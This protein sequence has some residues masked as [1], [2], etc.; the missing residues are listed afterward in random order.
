M[1]I[2]VIGTGYVGL[3]TGTCFAETGNEVICVDVDAAKVERL[4]QGHIPIF[5]PGLEAMV[6][7]NHAKGRLQF[8]T[9]L[10]LGINNSDISFIAVGTPPDED[11][12]ADLRHVLDVAKHIAHVATKKVIIGTKSTVPVGTGDKIEAIFKENLK[13]PFVVFSNPEFLKE[14]DAVGDFMKPDRIIVGLEHNGILTLLDELYAPFT[15]QKERL[16]IMNRRSAE[17]TKYAANAMLATRISFM[18]EMA[19]LC[20]KLGADINEVRK[21][22]G[23]DP[24]IG[25]AFLFAG[26]GYGGSCFPKDVKAILKTAADADQPLVVIKAAEAANDRQKKLLSGKIASHFGGSDK[27]TNKKFAIWGLSF[28]AK[29]DDI[30]ESAA[31]VVIDELLKHGSKICVFDPE[32][33]DNVKKIYGGKLLY[34]ANDYECLAGADGLILAT[35]WNEF[36]SPDFG[37]MKSVMKTPVIFDGRNILNKKHALDVGFTYYGMGGYR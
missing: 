16:L 23:S 6:L 4:N 32:A 28:K 30:R 29:T 37:R 1:K 25:P 33:M 21:G 14:G 19:N 7:Q 20:E 36:R 34:A 26:I 9:D 22:M 2:C 17:L 15:R 24:R 31:L 5:E 27:L 11:G 3:V 10:A 18:N 12:A 13:H 35:D 8:T